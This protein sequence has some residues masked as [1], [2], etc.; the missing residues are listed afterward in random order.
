MFSW[1]ALVSFA[2]KIKLGPC[3]VSSLEDK[4]RVFA[5]KGGILQ[6]ATVRCTSIFASINEDKFVV[7]IYHCHQHDTEVPLVVV[8]K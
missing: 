1:S 8:E 7:G 2:M 3:L 5:V 6:G 4:F